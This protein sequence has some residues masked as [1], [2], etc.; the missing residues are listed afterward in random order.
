MYYFDNKFLSQYLSQQMPVKV[1]SNYSWYEIADLQDL[2]D[3]VVGIGYDQFGGNHRF[4]YRDIEQVKIGNQPALDLKGLQ[5]LLKGEEPVPEKKVKSGTDLG[6]QE[7]LPSEEQSGEKEPDLSWFAPAFDI[8]R[9]ILSEF[10][11]K[12]RRTKR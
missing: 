7:E 5:D 4:D 1:Y 8:G 12:Q 11:K 3:K 10:E 2:K 6:G 9:N